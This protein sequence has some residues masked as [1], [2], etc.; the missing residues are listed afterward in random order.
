LEQFR[1]SGFPYNSA[2]TYAPPSWFDRAAYF[3]R[4]LLATCLFD[5]RQYGSHTHA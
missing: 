2:L 1:E 5:K 4:D 3:I